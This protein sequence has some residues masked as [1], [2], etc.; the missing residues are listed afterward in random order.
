VLK[1]N[2]E[3]GFK[4]SGLKMVKRSLYLKS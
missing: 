2:M 1:L 4:L 3:Q